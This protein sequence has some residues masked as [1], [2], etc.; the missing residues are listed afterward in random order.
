[1][2]SAEVL[3]MTQVEKEWELPPNLEDGEM[4]LPSDVLTDDD[5]RMETDVDEDRASQMNSSNG[6]GGSSPLLNS[7]ITDTAELLDA[8]LLKLKACEINWQH[9][10][11]QPHNNFCNSTANP[12]WQNNTYS[13]AWSPSAANGSASWNAYQYL[14]KKPSSVGWQ[15]APKHLQR[16]PTGFDENSYIP[17]VPAPGTNMRAQPASESTGTGKERGGTG[18]FLPRRTGR[19][20]ESRRK[21]KP[22]CS[23]VFLPYRVVQA[24]NLN[25]EYLN[26]R[27]TVRDL[28]ALKKDSNNGRMKAE[29]AK[30]FSRGAWYEQ[31]K[32][33]CAALSASE[34]S[35]NDIGLPQ[36]WTY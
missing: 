18:F 16:A 8:A 23:T 14:Q 33:T 28:Y 27:T 34:V 30:A 9:Q 11:H 35:S 17:W 32:Q 25:I 22:A 6:S 36:E 4:W 26:T 24:L 21:K 1:M 2:A 12:A 20:N 31:Q 19:G 7:G 5:D 3:Q 15:Q 13:S 10:N 29:N